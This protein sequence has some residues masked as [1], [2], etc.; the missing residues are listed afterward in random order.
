MEALGGLIIR[1]LWRPNDWR[2][3]KRLS[4]LWLYPGSI[5]KGLGKGFSTLFRRQS[6]VD[7]PHR[8]F[9]MGWIMVGV[10][11]LTGLGL[12]WVIFGLSWIILGL[13]WAILGMCWAYIGL[14]WPCFKL[15]LGCLGLVLGLAWP[16]WEYLMLI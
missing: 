5:R 2:P 16:S 11:G 12:F 7:H 15:V 14:S 8:L 1:G 10:F 13:P 6:H 3:L 9:F 4:S